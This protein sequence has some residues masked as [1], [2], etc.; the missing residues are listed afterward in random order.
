MIKKIILF[1]LLSF[2]N[3][4]GGVYSYLSSSGFNGAYGELNSFVSSENNEIENYWKNEI[5]PLIEKINEEIKKKE[6]NTKIIKELEK[7]YLLQTKEINFLLEKK[8]QL[9]SNQANIISE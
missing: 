2:Q 8:K 4:F 3:L 1:F 5:K 9:L 6:K 7:K